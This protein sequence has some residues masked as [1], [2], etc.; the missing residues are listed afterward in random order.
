MYHTR[1]VLFYELRDVLVF[2]ALFDRLYR[3]CG[4]PHN[5]QVKRVS[6]EYV[7]FG[8]VLWTRLVLL[9][10]DIVRTVL[11]IVVVAHIRQRNEA[12]GR[13]RPPVA[14]RHNNVVGPK[15]RRG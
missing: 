8:L 15:K 11:D 1:M 4:N 3:G 12:G 5:T 10:D 2:V 7:L 9:V 14:P 6:F 13:Q